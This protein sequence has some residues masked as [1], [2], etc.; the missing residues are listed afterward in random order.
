[1]NQ[2]DVE[3][4]IIGAEYVDG[5]LK[6]PIEYKGKKF[7]IY[8]EEGET[9]KN[10]F[11]LNPI[12]GPQDIYIKGRII[13][14]D[15]ASNIYKY[16]VLEDLNTRQSLKVS[17]DAGSLSGVFPLGQ[18]VAV[19]CNGLMMGRYAEMPQLGVYSFRNDDKTRYEPGRIPY[20]M[21]YDHFQR[22]GLPDK[23]KVT[24]PHDAVLTMAEI[25]TLD[26]TWYGRLIKIENVE[27]TWKNDRDADLMTGVVSLRRSI[28]KTGNVNAHQ[29]SPVFAPS[30]YD[31]SKKYNIGYPMSREVSDG[32]GTLYIST[33]EYAHFAET[34]IPKKGSVG[35]VTAILG[36]FHD[37]ND[38]YGG[39]Y[40]LTIRSLDDLEGFEY[41]NG[42][43]E[44]AEG[45][46]P[47]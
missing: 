20:S 12:E 3:Y 25:A 28:E 39:K 10:L 46:R 47:Q 21:V 13:S 37:K 40:Q 33:S 43:R 45:E 8:R 16:F 6:L 30:T 24:I 41:Y 27:F 9:Y 18:V 42:P 31:M 34:F 38:N 44:Y 11:T 23:S 36:W 29:L 14:A 22:I 26:S 19:K 17:I 7:T 4:P 1:M 35:T 32:T 5:R 2:G 15:T